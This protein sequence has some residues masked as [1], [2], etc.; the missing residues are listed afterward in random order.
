MEHIYEQPQF[1][2]NWF[3]YP[4]LYSRFVN[5][6]EDG[7][8]I[9]EVGCWKGKSVA[10]LA[11]EIINSGKNITI[12]AVDTWKGSPNETICQ[13]DPFVK[14]DKLYEL[15]LE[16]ISPFSEIVNPIRME[17]TEAASLYEDG[18]LDVV[19]IDAG[20]TY[21]EVKADIIAWLPKVKKGGYISGH[22]YS[23]GWES[24]AKAVDE[25]FTEKEIT[26]Y[27]WVYKIG[28]EK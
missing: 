4:N 20:H 9:V 25:F 17:S 28:D 27:C 16:N 14:E 1:G 13:E 2:E 19:F 5:E 15:F 8:K 7:S 22:D 3:T 11:V 10:Y 23:F 12:D 18:S 26:E 21:E 24:V 6:L